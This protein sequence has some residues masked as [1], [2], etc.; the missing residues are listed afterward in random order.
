MGDTDF[1]A[2]RTKL[3]VPGLRREQV[4]RR[5]LV[6][7]LEAGRAR[8]LTL[9]SAPTGFGKTSTLTAWAAASPA[10]FG[11]VALDERDDE[12]TRFWSYVVAAIES[13]AP[14]VPGTAARRLRAPGVSI[15]DEVLPVL[16]NQ[17]A[18]VTQPLVVV[19]DDYHAISDPA[20]HAGVS[21]VLDRLPQ[22]VHVVLA[23]QVDP[24]LL[25][26]RLRASDELNE[27]RAAQLRFTDEEAVALLNGKHGLRLA[28]E[29]LAGLQHRTEGWV[30]GLNL[31][32]LS[33]R[34]ASNRDDLMARMPVQD[35][36]LVDYLWDEVA[37]QQSP[38][39]RQFL[40]KTS[41][42]ERLSSSLCDAVTGR[43]DSAERLVDLERSNLFVVPLDAER[44][45][46]RYH[47][48]F[49]ATL[50]RQLE[51]DAPASIVDLHRRASAWFADHDEL[52]GAIEH[53][54]LAGDVHVAADT[55]QRN[56]LNLYS[57]GQAAQ[58]IAWID[59][60]PRETMAEYPE[61]ALARGG[62]A[63][64][65]GRIDELEPWLE[66]VEWAAEQ[67]PSDAQR[68]ELLAG[69]AR[70]R[71]MMG[72]AQANVG[73]AVRNG[74]LAVELRPEGSKETQ[75]DSFFLGICLF[76][77]AATA[78]AEQRLRSYLD[79][80]SPGDQDVRRVFAMAL[81]AEA[82]ACRGELDEAERLIAESF[83]T[84]EARG[85]GEHP[86]T[87]QTYVA[88]GIVLLARGDVERAEDSLEHATT[89]ARR[90]GDLIE[91]AHALL[92][93]GRTRARAGDGS[94]ASDALD[95]ARDAL[96]GARVPA[97]VELTRAV[98]TEIREVPEHDGTA[99]YASS[100]GDP[101]SAAEL[102]VLE[103]LPTDLTY[104]EIAAQLYLSLNTVR[105]HGQRIRRKLGASTRDEAVSAAR[106]LELL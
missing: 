100:D 75:S 83:S 22:D 87:E 29:Q 90:G 50:L 34:N 95:A 37:V 66:L 21:Y 76:W 59:R 55:L 33:L 56:W 72:L 10:R 15:A 12:P 11:W 79:A 45:W 51:R 61:L 36:F 14:E 74:R 42:L 31:V 67:Q 18:Q 4:T 91:I 62:V 43:S 23:G 46:Y 30:A 35:R 93:L 102:R 54:I 63:R 2:V 41:V 32:A 5:G 20:I 86:P 48:L 104:R 57:G 27:V 68:R 19:L 9:V 101:L 3:T 39:T 73:E 7:M 28:P 13:V 17:L 97:L 26:G 92:W 81:L 6:R 44:R 16:V 106:R 25:F 40:M 82:H 1:V 103:L 94:G 53:A 70:Q 89:L 49:R 99:E 64:A 105:T 24:P 85:L 52:G 96:A 78:E 71:A 38:E 60:L 65:M 8:R 80:T 77:S 88:R 69:V 47:H 58:S 98:E 84:T